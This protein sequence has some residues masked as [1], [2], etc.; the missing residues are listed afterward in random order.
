MRIILLPLLLTVSC[1]REPEVLQEPTTTARPYISPEL[2]VYVERFLMDCGY[3]YH[4]GELR[5][6]EI[7]PTRS[8]GQE[9]V[10]G[11][12]ES[13]PGG[14]EVLIS[15]NLTDFGTMLTV[16]HELGHCLLDR[17]HSESGIMAAT[18]TEENLQNISNNWEDAVDALC[19]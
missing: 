13:G 12:C 9:G 5:A 1:Y 4:W 6:I 15:P 7:Y 10:A 19:W 11:W 8:R 3:G 14:R 17:G 2:V 18:H 16:Y